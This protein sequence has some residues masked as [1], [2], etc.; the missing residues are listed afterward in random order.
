[1][2]RPQS[3]GRPGPQRSTRSSLPHPAVNRIYLN[4]S[5]VATAAGLHPHTQRTELLLKTFQQL[6]PQ[7]Y[8]AAHTRAQTLSGP[9]AQMQAL[10]AMADQS[11]KATKSSQLMQLAAEDNAAA[12]AAAMHQAAAAAVQHFS[13]A[14][15]S[16]TVQALQ[17]AAAAGGDVLLPQDMHE[18]LAAA[19]AVPGATAA[20]IQAAVPSGPDY[21]VAAALQCAAA[22][23][24]AA[25]YAQR[26]SQELVSGVNQERGRQSEPAALA[27]AA[28][29][30]AQPVVHSNT[31]MYYADIQLVKATGARQPGVRV[32]LGGKVDGWL[33]D[34]SAFVE[35]KDR[36]NSSMYHV[37]VYERVQVL[38]YMHCTRVGKCLFTE[39]YLENSRGVGLG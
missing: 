37:P 3:S 17:Q 32:K 5:E 23:E 35:V 29:A 39:K 13:D 28:E 36:Q 4:A 22:K 27:A 11:L 33:E 15:R 2:L 25:A 31:Q 1:M 24:A 30:A 12:R 38:A 9:N 19:A 10:R 8:A 21:A 7:Q 26:I 6:R 14:Q 16:H 34:R 20:D 18:Q